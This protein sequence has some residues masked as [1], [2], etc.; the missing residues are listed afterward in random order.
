MWSNLSLAS[1]ASSLTDLSSQVASTVA[2]TATTITAQA[3]HFIEDEKR[4]YAEEE[5]KIER[6]RQQQQFAATHSP[7]PALP[8][9]H[10][11]TEDKS[12]L[13][14]ELKQR[15]L[16]LASDPRSF[17]SS[18]PD[19]ALFPFSLELALPHIQLALK[20]DPLLA[21]MQYRLVPRKVSERQFWTNYMYRVA[22]VREQMGVGELFEVGRVEAEV[23]RE[24]SRAERLK[25]QQDALEKDKRER[26][27]RIK[28]ALKNDGT[29]GG[30]EKAE[31]KQQEKKEDDSAST[32]SKA[33]AAS[34]PPTTSSKVA[35][36]PP[37]SERRDSEPDVEFAS[38]SY[39]E[40]YVHVAAQD[41]ALVGSMR[42]ELGLPPPSAHLLAATAGKGAA[43][44]GAKGDSADASEAEL[45]ELESMLE[46]TDASATV[47]VDGGSDE[48]LDELEEE[49]TD[50]RHLP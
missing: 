26:Q 31:R 27:E 3:Q 32:Q 30:E 37:V 7:P 29:A 5:A 9:W 2:S 11:F 22:C 35:P 1:L 42:E 28:G 20:S 8:L 48:L 4:S 50:G 49:L 46:D 47:G 14:A 13:E 41:E 15:I 17:L 36:P 24:R 16:R 39:G 23:E 34:P 21:R 10:T 18:A 38:D 12:V 33:S 45:D 25:A 43:Q 19:S 6:Q 44:S 40:E